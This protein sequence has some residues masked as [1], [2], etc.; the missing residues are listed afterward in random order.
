M[1]SGP[2]AP[3]LSAPAPGARAPGAPRL[4][5]VALGRLG[6]ALVACGLLGAVAWGVF[7]SPLG[8]TRY[9]L[10]ERDRTFTIHRAGTYVVYI[11]YPGASGAALPPALDINVASLAGR[12]IEVRPLGASG[13]RSAPGAYRLGPYEGRA[14]ALI[15]AREAG[16]FL[17]TIEPTPASQVDP[18]QEQVIAEATIALGRGWSR[19]WL[20]SWGGVVLV[21]MA[22]ILAG[23]IL[24]AMGWRRGRQPATDR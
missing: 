23:M 4:G 17:V 9:P 12:P 11:E 5:S 15:V 21:V 1:I 19:G 13:L 24:M 8:F 2:L 20:A 22:P 6:L 7:V 10:T 14:V 3:D 18:S 16:T